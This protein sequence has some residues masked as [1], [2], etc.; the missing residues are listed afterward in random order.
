MKEKPVE[1][2]ERSNG[3]ALGESVEEEIGSVEEHHN[4]GTTQHK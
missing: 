3:D 2:P 1:L 4:S